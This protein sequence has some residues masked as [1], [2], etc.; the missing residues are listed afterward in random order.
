MLVFGAGD[1]GAQ[2]VSLLVANP[3]Q[4]PNVGDAIVAAA[5]YK[6]FRRL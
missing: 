5:A 4:P 6:E 2:G 1:E 3:A